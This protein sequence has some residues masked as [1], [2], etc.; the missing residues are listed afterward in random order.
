MGRVTS[1][2]NA[3]NPCILNAWRQYEPEIKG[4]LAHRLADRHLA[5][6]LLQQVF[7]NAIR[8]G[9]RFC[10]LNHPRAWLFQVAR[11][12][13]TDH[14]RLAKDIVPLP[15]D[16]IQDEEPTAPIDAL[17]GCV[18][19]VLNELSEKERDVI[20]QCDLAG[21]KMQIYADRH[22]MTLCAVKSRIQRA[23]KRMRELMT[24][25]CQVRFD[26]VGNVCCHVPRAPR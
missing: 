18:E 4:Y 16:L 24:R 3:G 22:G 8:Q 23:R 20:R 19:R 11:N 7:V 5:E 26:E 12:A 9:D 14:M 21:M 17:A 2:Q 25:N 15:E 13:L 1:A 6:D 10:S